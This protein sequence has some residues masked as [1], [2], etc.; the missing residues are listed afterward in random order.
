M[1]SIRQRG[2]NS[3]QITVSSGYNKGTKLTKQKT[4]K[5]PE[6][7]TDKQ[8]EKELDSLAHE[9]EREVEHGTYHDPS[10]YT[11]SDFA[12]KWLEERGKDL[13]NKTRY[14]Y[15]SMLNERVAEVIGHL[16][17]DQVKP[18]HLLDFYSNLAEAGI[19]EDTKYIALPELKAIMESKKM[20]IKVLSSKAE[21]SERTLKE[22]LS[23]KRTSVAKKISK[24]LEIKLEKIFIPALEP[25]QLSAKTIGHY[26]RVLSVMF[27]DAV[28]W[29]LLRENPCLKVQPPKVT[30]KEM[31]CL[32]ED[33]VAAMLEC[34]ESETIK[35]KAMITL[36]L[37]TGCRRGE[38]CALQWQHIDLN[39]KILFVKQSAEYTPATGIRIKQPKTASS[40]RK[41]S[42][43]ESTVKLL[44]QYR[45]WQL[46][47]KAK[48]V[49]LWQQ[50]E[51]EKQGD[52][53]KDPEW[54]FSTWDGYI[55]HPDTLTDLF[56]K[57]LKRHN[58]PN[59][60][61]HDIRHTAATH[62]INSGLNVRAVAARLGHANPNVTLTV[63]SHALQSADRQAAD[64]ME[65]LATKRSNSSTAK[66]A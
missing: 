46:E 54:V 62:L 3:W 42:L 64:I 2:I 15:E 34:L 39:N 36:A 9:F 37:M 65:N 48:V 53:W 13:E 4:V 25:G 17:L 61:L 12:K 23:G 32:D 1:A 44:K 16:K 6:G 20:D 35:N 52:T 21:I 57:F 24:T 7:M 55:I 22:I 8:W 40:N 18:L 19:R 41:L 27:N 59:I 51:K 43:P 26:H 38:I 66:Q 30:K 47:E 56:K 11:L 10:K 29:G 50:E 28:R 14:R 5:R 31:S 49:N 63:Y 45:K 33:G 60:R 58:L